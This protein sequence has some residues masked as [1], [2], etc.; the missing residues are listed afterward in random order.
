MM[1]RTNLNKSLTAAAAK[2]RPAADADADLIDENN[3]KGTRSEHMETSCEFYENKIFLIIQS[4]AGILMIV[5]GL[6]QSAMKNP[7]GWF[8]IML[9]VFMIFIGVMRR[10]YAIVAFTNDSITMKKAPIRPRRSVLYKQVTHA[11]VI[12][13]KKVTIHFE[14]DGIKES[15]ALP[16]GSM[17]GKDRLKVV[18]IIQSKFGVEK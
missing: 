13:H 17:S 11:E 6:L 1:T 15:M 16:L 5:A 10:S 9:G 7:M 3:L 2:I 12:S 14:H 8:F 18:D 4:I